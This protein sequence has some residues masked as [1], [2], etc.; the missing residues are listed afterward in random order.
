MGLFRKETQE[1]GTHKEV[2]M[3]F[4]GALVYK[5]WFV[6]GVRTSS[7]VFH[8]GEGVTQLRKK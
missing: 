7:K 8:G 3:Y 4:L 6:C 1:D 2:Y 5:M